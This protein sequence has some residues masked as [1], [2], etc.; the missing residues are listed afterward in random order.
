MPHSKGHSVLS[1]FADSH[2]PQLTFYQNCGFATVDEAAIIFNVALAFQGDWLDIGGHT[3]WTGMHQAAAGCE[4]IA[5][6]PMYRVDAF[7]ERALENIGDASVNLFAGTAREFFAQNQKPFD[8]VMIDGDHLPPH[9]EEDAR[10]ACAWLNERGVIIFHDA[11]GQP[12]Q[13][14]IRYL[15]SSGF[16]HKVYWTPHVVTVCWRGEFMPPHHVPDPEVK[17]SVQQHWKI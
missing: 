12:V 14:G 10:N 3:G 17:A 16:N 2:D 1:D 8:G 9:P 7:R 11:I 6:D 13:D 4:V 15:I 5:V